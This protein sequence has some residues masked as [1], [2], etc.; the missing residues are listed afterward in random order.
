ME[1]HISIKVKYQSI[2]CIKMKK[3]QDIV[4]SVTREGSA[5]QIDM[6]FAVSRIIMDKSKQQHGPKIEREL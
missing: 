5:E 3:G 6:K 2:Y 1:V 4:A